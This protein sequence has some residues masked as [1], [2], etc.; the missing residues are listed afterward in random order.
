MIMKNAIRRHTAWSFSYL[1][2]TPL[3]QF[4]D[5]LALFTHPGAVFQAIAQICV[6]ELLRIAESRY[7]K[8]RDD[9][10]ESEVFR[11]F[12]TLFG[13][14]ATVYASAFVD[15]F[16]HDVL[17]MSGRRVLIVEAKAGAFKEP[18]RDVVR[19]VTRLKQNF[20]RVIQEGYTQGDRTARRL[21]RGQT[22]E[23]RDRKGEPLVT[24]QGT[25]VDEVFVLCITAD[26]FGPLALDLSLLLQK[27]ANAPYPWAANFFD[28]DTFLAA[29][30][31]IGLPADALFDFL[32]ERQHLHGRIICD[33]ELELAGLFL[34]G[35][36]LQQ[37]D[38]GPGTKTLVPGDY[39]QVFDDLFFDEETEDGPEE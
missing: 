5:E 21:R 3:I 38:G 16:E 22:V 24:I 33:D 26:D 18:F 37:L 23:F 39:S 10:L 28:A 6:T 15:E 19:S 4:D 8:R 14:S 13:T 7:L 11:I 9:L 20:D 1:E 25:D 36:C 35:G 12:Q 27:G 29:F 17:V 34:Q 2:S 31:Q 30:P 32:R